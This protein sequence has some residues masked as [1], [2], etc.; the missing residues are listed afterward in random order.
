MDIVD[1]DTYH[2]SYIGQHKIG[3]KEPENDN[4]KGSGSEW[5][6]QILKNNIPVKKTILKIC[7]NIEDTNYWE[8]Y[9]IEQALQNGEYLWNIAKGGGGHESDKIYTEEELKQHNRE[10][11]IKW[12]NNNQD[13]VAEYRKKYY[14]ENKEKIYKT[15]KE[16]LESHKEYYK[17]YRKKYYQNN[18]ESISKQHKDYYEAHKDEMREK[19]KEYNKQYKIANAEKE[20]IRHKQYYESHKEE[21]NNY[22]TRPCLYDGKTMTFRALILRLMRKNIEHPTEVAKQYLI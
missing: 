11:F 12:Y 22:Y 15:N 18:K 3:N 6:K 10:R 2:G 8:R 19:R 9:Y 20:A 7:D 16:Y 13:Y 4:Y 14:K 1:N 5:K 21:R 17:E